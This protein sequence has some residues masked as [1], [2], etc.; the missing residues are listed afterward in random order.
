MVETKSGPGTVHRRP[1]TGLRIIAVLLWLVALAAG[2]G[3]AWIVMDLAEY[4]GGFLPWYLIFA[5]PFGLLLGAVAVGSMLALGRSPRIAPVLIG[6]VVVGIA[7]F[8]A[9]G[10]LGARSAEQ[11][12]REACSVDELSMFEAMSFSDDFDAS[13]TGTPSGSCYV[14]YTIDRTGRDAWIE[15][16]ELL[17]DNGWQLSGESWD[18]PESDPPFSVLTR[19]GYSMVVHVEGSHDLPGDALQ[20]SD[21]GA[22]TFAL[23]ITPNA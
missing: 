19:D 4:E 15:L 14:V 20:E 10:F 18:A 9:A 7:L 23:D 6:S 12:T 17:R 21:D 13:P 16:A 11:S 3:G 5:V 2:A 22:T 1:S 8:T